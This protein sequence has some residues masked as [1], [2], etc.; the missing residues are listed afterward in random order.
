MSL[1]FTC[2]VPGKKYRRNWGG[3]T[4][5]VEIRR[6]KDGVLE[7]IA[8]SGLI[9]FPASMPD[10][11]WVPVEFPSCW[12]CRWFKDTPVL[13]ECHHPSLRARLGGW[14]LRA[15]ERASKH[16]C[17]PDGVNFTP[18]THPVA[19]AIAGSHIISGAGAPVP[20]SATEAAST[21]GTR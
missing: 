12:E 19:R 9:S 21:G 11:T 18:V 1:P 14:N 7:E 2:L 8:P 20:A 15:L 17:G 5:V 13:T 4:V 3:S 10:A 16:G 6:G